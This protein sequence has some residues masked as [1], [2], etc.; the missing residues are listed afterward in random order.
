MQTTFVHV[1]TAMVLAQA[2]LDLMDTISL[3]VRSGEDII[4]VDKAAQ[5]LTIDVFGLTGFNFDF[6][7]RHYQRCE[8]FEVLLCKF[9]CQFL[10]R[11]AA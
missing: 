8:L 11:Y 6:G 1:L 9:A 2:V 3:K 10:Q 5:R 7:A 4:D